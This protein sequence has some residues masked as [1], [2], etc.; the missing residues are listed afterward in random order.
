M[1]PAA[2]YYAACQDGGEITY[3]PCSYAENLVEFTYR[4]ER[5]HRR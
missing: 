4:E 1:I 3:N 2:S 5:E